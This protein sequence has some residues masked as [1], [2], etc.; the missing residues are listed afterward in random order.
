MGVFL[1]CCE[2]RKQDPLKRQYIYHLHGVTYYNLR[3]TPPSNL[4]S[5]MVPF[6]MVCA[7]ESSTS[8]MSRSM[9]FLAND[10]DLDRGQWYRMREFRRFYI[11]DQ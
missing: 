5:R 2:W 10:F 3:F 4:K 9:Q 8:T 11:Y 7:N 6:L 1:L